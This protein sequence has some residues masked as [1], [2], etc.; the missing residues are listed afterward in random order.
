VTAPKKTERVERGWNT[1][2]EETQSH[3]VLC[4]KR[5]GTPHKSKAKGSKHGEKKRDLQG[6][7]SEIATPIGGGGLEHRIK[8]GSNKGATHEDSNKDCGGQ[9]ERQQCRANSDCQGGISRKLPKRKK[10]NS[11]G[12]ISLEEKKRQ[13]VKGHWR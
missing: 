1:T 6:G 4:G 3:W 9:N 10:A 2:N 12:A 13:Y 7:K 8:G 5:R 11:T